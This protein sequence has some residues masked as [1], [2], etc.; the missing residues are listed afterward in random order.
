MLFERIEGVCF[1][2]WLFERYLK[3]NANDT[4]ARK[5]RD[6]YLE[7]LKDLINQYESDWEN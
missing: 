7:I 1:R 3:D 6:R 5:I 2:L 4:E